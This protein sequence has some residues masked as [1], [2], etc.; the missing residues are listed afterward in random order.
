MIHPDLVTPAL[1]SRF[2]T[3]IEA[4][5]QLDHPGIAR[6]FDA[7]FHERPQGPPIPFFAMELVEG[8]PL[9]R[10]SAEHRKDQK[11]LLRMIMAICSAIQSAHERRIVHR[12][13]KPSNILIKADGQPVVVDF[14]IARLAGAIT[15]EERGLFSGTFAYAAPEQHLGCDGD[16]RSGESVDVYA[17]GAILFEI[18][19]GRRL[20]NFP[21]GATIAERRKMVLEDKIPRL[22]EV[23]PD[24]PPHLD[25]VV[26]RALRRDPAD[27][28]YSMV[29]LGRAISRT[30]DLK[31]AP[32][33]P[34][35]W[36]PATDKVI[37]GTQWRLVKKVGEGG[38]GQVWSGRHDQLD[39]SRIFK[40]CDTEDKARMLKRELT[41]Y[42]LLK[43]QVGLNPHFIQLHDVSLDEPPY[44]LMMDDVDALDL[45]IWAEKQTGGLASVPEHVRLEIVAQAAEALQAAHEAGILHRDIKPA[46]LLVQE[47]EKTGQVHVF[48]TDFG[49]G[50]IIVNGLLQKGTLLGFTSTVSGM[51]SGPVSGTLIY[52]APEVLEGNAATI[53]SDIYSLGVVLWQMLIGN[54]HAALDPADWSTRIS[55][56]LLREDLARCLAGAPE[57]R[58]PSAGELA[59]RLRDLPARRA[60]TA[61]RQR[62]LAARERAAYRQGVLKTAAVAMVLIA[63]FATMATLAWIQ[64]RDAR[65]ANGEL[66]MRQAMTLKQTEFASGRRMHGMSLLET[67]ASTVTNIGALRTASAAVL[68]MADLTPMASEK[69]A[70]QPDIAPGI[71][72]QPHELA[73]IMSHNRS[74]VAVARDLDG[75]N[76]AI[77]LF[78]TN[79]TRIS[80]IERKQFPWV[81]LGEPGLFCFSPDDRLL[82]IGGPATSRHILICNVADGSL[83]TY[84]FHGSDPLCCAWHSDGHIIAVG[85]ADAI[86]I[87]DT[88]AGVKPMSTAGTGNQFDLP[89]VLDVPA[90]DEPLHIL[91]GQR[92]PVTHVAFSSGGRWLAAVD[93]AGYLRIYLCFFRDGLPQVTHSDRA[94]ELIIG[95]DLTAPTFATEVRLNNVEPVTSL[96]AEDDRILIHHAGGLTEEFKFVPGELPAEISAPPGITDIAWNAGGTEICTKSLTDIYWLRAMPLELI[97]TAA[98]QNPTGI[99]SEGV[100]DKWMV[101]K[102]HK[103]TEWGSTKGDKT[104]DIKL[105][106]RFDLSEAVPGQGTRTALSTSRDGRTAIYCGKRIQFFHDHKLAPPNTSIIANGG[107]GHFQGIFW[108]QS[109]RL[110]GVSFALPTGGVRLETWQT[111][112]NFPPQCHACAPLTLDCQGVTP[113]NDGHHFLARGGHRGLWEF[114]PASGAETSLDTSSA[115]CQ[116]A[117]FS[118]TCDGS[119][120]AFVIDH[121]TIR[122][123]KLP[124][125]TFFADLYS[126][127]QAD[128]TGLA[129]DKSG[130]HLASITGDDFIQVWNLSPWQEWMATHSL[131]K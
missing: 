76:G 91:R 34:A 2:I 41:L 86:R 124:S 39:E 60:A 75:L 97:Q 121:T 28:F 66:A 85:C 116:N 10:W 48:V 32:A 71:A 20:F 114:D 45:E 31:N 9:D 56:P 78:G 8:P 1:Q 37:P 51:G 113:A 16:F 122:L 11:A 42:R 49:I 12:D 57:K 117:P 25:E 47:N 59:A 53:R 106:S 95:Q 107:D 104:G 64:R 129:W 70:P 101:A 127:R 13:L 77:D 35:P 18:F 110:L 90:E 33:A 83:K 87:W 30:V 119:L 102:E 118:S 108:D 112:T 65:R 125:G 123:L 88:T 115:A 5:G 120:A 43:G 58:W 68:G 23:I 21:H 103:V 52:L 29:A 15:G 94:D 130:T 96:E 26:S 7:G 36:I 128:L 105:A 69:S 67:A 100:E 62:E 6:I 131:Q 98:G 81:P 40:F 74:M 80:T 93:A 92:G 111:T 44:Y 72:K 4:L 46:N 73:R 61:M 84:L 89:P 55:D 22:S 63:I 3:E 19:A 17:V 50:Q 27:R 14:G 79:G 99:S 38:T 24:C 126:P 54:L 82:A 109:G